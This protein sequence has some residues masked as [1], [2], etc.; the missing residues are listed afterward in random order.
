ME[1]ICMVEKEEIEQYIQLLN[2]I[3]K[4]ELLLEENIQLKSKELINISDGDLQE[5]LFSLPVD[6]L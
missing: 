5:I 4:I 3:Q 1:E 2:Y 6:E